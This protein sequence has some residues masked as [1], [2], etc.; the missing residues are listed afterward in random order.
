MRIT[1]GISLELHKYV[2]IDL[3]VRSHVRMSTKKKQKYKNKVPEIVA[4]TIL[5]IAKITYQFFRNFP[6]NIDN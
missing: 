3:S 6:F 4:Y 1:K 5:D 2:K